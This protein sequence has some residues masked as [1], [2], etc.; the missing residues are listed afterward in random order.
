MIWHVAAKGDQLEGSSQH[1]W[2]TWLI[3]IASDACCLA[4]LLRRYIL[5][6]WEILFALNHTSRPKKS[7][8]WLDIV[9]PAGSFR[10]RLGGLWRLCPSHFAQCEGR[11]FAPQRGEQRREALRSSAAKAHCFLSLVALGWDECGKQVVYHEVVFIVL[12]MCDCIQAPENSGHW[13]CADVP[14]ECGHWLSAPDS[15]TMSQ[16]GE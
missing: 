6:V 12:W 3:K 14:D 4:L 8:S 5:W 13:P 9:I 7:R 2:L 10:W 16:G 1:R 15:W 11:W